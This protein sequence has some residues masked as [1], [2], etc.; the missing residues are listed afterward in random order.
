[1]T[2]G[3]KETAKRALQ[4]GVDKFLRPL[5]LAAVPVE[6]AR[7]CAWGSPSILGSFPPFSDY[8]CVGS[9]ENYFIHE[10]Y[11]HRQEAQYFDDTRYA[12]E[13][14]LEVYLCAR[15]ISDREKLSTVCDIGCGSGYKLL[16]YLGGLR[17]VGVDLPQTCRWLKQKYPDHSWIESD[18]CAK[19]DYPVDLVIAA[20]VIEHLINPDQLMAY[21]VSLR[22][23]YVILSTPDRNLLRAGTHN[24]PP[25]NCAH[26]REWNLVEFQAYV[27]E[28]FEILEHFVS[29]APQATQ[30]IV[31][32]PKN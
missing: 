32:Q 6:V 30:C 27:K 19:P 17:T 15:E 20:D 23:R 24:G 16:K 28:Y 22:A 29:S 10:G 31:C 9:R 12:D 14:Q 25:A 8:F 4:L 2:H 11:Q 18:F 3:A 21:I 13:S 1:M 7:P 5:G 26:V